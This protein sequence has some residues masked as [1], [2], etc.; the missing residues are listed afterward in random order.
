MA[1]VLLDNV[2]VDTFFDATTLE[3]E[4]TLLCLLDACANRDIAKHLLGKEFFLEALAQLQRD[5]QT[6][7]YIKSAAKKVEKA[8]HSWQALEDA[9]TNDDANFQE[10]IDFVLEVTSE[11]NSTG[12]WLSCM[13]ASD[14]LAA[15]IRN[16]NPGVSQLPPGLTP[17]TRPTTSAEFVTLI[18]TFIGVLCVLSAWAWADSLGVDECRERILA[19]LSLWQDIDNYREV[20]T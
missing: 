19:V 4:N 16:T 7:E 13:L 12:V 8:I 3:D 5:I 6:D 2:D 11:E 15:K 18:R 10:A 17:S 9:L 20:R 1:S 14:D